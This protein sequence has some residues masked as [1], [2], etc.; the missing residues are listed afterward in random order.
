MKNLNT[1]YVNNKYNINMTISKW[2]CLNKSLDR[3]TMLK[4][5]D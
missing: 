5:I 4:V 2:V 3:D 1:L